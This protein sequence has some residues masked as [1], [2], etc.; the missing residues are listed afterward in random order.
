MNS[1]VLAS[2]VDVRGTNSSCK[3]NVDIIDNNDIRCLSGTLDFIDKH[4]NSPT[5][6]AAKD[7]KEPKEKKGSSLNKVL[8]LIVISS[9]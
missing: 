8:I 1:N 9:L 4:K 7:E 6:Q 2:C 5:V 3:T